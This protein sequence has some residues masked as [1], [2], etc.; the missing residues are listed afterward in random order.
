MVLL[1]LSE[2]ILPQFRAFLDSNL[3]FGLRLKGTVEESGDT[4]QLWIDNQ[5]APRIALHIRRGWIAPVGETTSILSHLEEM[6]VL[7]GE[8]AGDEEVLR[9]FSF[10]D[11]ARKAVAANV[12]INGL[13]IVNDQTVRPPNHAE[14]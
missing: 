12:T 1:R 3:P 9:F 14:P 8:F 4:E 10:S 13:P 7:A 11:G 2:P 5:D 6:E